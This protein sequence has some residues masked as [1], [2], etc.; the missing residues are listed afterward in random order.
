LTNDCHHQDLEEKIL[1][2]LREAKG[3]ILDDE[4]LINTLDSSKSTSAL[5]QRRVAEAEETEKSINTAREHYRPV[6]ARASSLYFV[7][8]DLAAMNPMCATL[9]AFSPLKTITAPF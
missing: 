5:L 4:S 8:A 7:M 6:A 2:M 3:N 1:K 9:L